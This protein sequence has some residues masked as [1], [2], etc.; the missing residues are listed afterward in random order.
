MTPAAEPPADAQLG[1]PKSTE[2]GRTREAGTN[3][4]SGWTSRTSE[5]DPRTQSSARSQCGKRAS[6]PQPRRP[7]GAAAG[8]GGGA[9]KGEA[10]S[11]H[12][13]LRPRRL[14]G[15]LPRGSRF[16]SPGAEDGEGRG[17]WEQ[18]LPLQRSAGSPQRAP[19]P[20]G[21]TD[22]SSLKPGHLGL[23]GKA[24]SDSMGSPAQRGHNTL[25]TMTEKHPYPECQV[26]HS[27]P[28]DT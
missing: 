7:E 13:R 4:H 10:R 2:T 18:Q 6:P 1:W 11:P 8:A 22:P 24:W 20:W 12:A 17:W 3:G 23:G 21:H 16:R 14:E 28:R 15:L 19:E 25:R 5:A 26:K 27:K 9:P